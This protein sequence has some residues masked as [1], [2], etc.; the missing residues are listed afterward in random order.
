MTRSAGAA[1][2]RYWLVAAGALLV[3]KGE[4]TMGALIACSILSGRVLAPVAM[5]PSQ[6]AQWSHTKAALQGLD[7]LWSLQDDHH[8]QQQPVVPE[9]IRGHYELDAITVNYGGRLALSIAKLN[10]APGEKI[11][12]LGPVGAGKTEHAASAAG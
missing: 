8:G 5:I 2:R 10:I 1:Q 3:S 11:G 7:R 6:L 9:T 12:V 4:L